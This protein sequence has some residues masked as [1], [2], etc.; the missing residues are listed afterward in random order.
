LTKTFVGGAM[1]FH[2]GTAGANVGG[3]DHL[4]HHGR[5][6]VTTIILDPRPRI[7]LNPAVTS[8][9]DFQYEDFEVLDYN[10]HPHIPGKV[11]V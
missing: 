8:L 9:F 6:I 10:P 5:R 1:L 2:P 4:D 11:A 3:S 7:Q